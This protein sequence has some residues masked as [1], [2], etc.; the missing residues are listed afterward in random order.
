MI[1]LILTILFTIIF[2]PLLKEFSI[3]KIDTQQAI[4]FNYIT[5]SVLGLLFC[6]D[7][8]NL[9]IIAAS[10]WILPTIGLGVFFIVVFNITAITTQKL[11]I[12]IGSMASKMSLIIPVLGS[13][14]L[15][16]NTSITTIQVIGIFL[17]LS[18][19][20][21]TFRKSEKH[22]YPITI[23]VIL[24]FGAG[25]LD[26]TINFIQNNYLITKTDH[27][28]F[29]ITVFLVAFLVGVLKI[30]FTNTKV[31]LRNVLA[32]ISLGV[33]NYFSI[34]FLLKSLEQLGG[35][36]VFPVLN[37]AV[38]LLS[39]I[40]SW[41]FYQENMSKLNWFGVLLACLSIMLVLR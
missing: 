36:I 14:L 37:I 28:F 11:G 18:S 40:I 9:K 22:T 20:Y 25:I 35:I 29:I 7:S 8:I 3:R 30:L 1:S 10:N 17:A 24:F 15:Q 13:Y 31:K 12:S 41:Y 16:K 4:T 32:G 5:A 23:A 39:A 19:I 27:S 33:P 38:V 34:Y 6:P 2:F 26:S 21:F